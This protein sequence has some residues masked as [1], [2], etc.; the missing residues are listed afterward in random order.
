MDEKSAGEDVGSVQNLYDAFV[1]IAEQYDD[2]AAIVYKAKR[3]TYGQLLTY[4]RQIT[5][6]LLKQSDQG[7]VAIHCE[8]NEYLVA[9]ILGV[10][11]SGRSYLYLDKRDSFAY[12]CSI[13]AAVKCKI[14]LIDN[15]LIEGLPSDIKVFEVQA[16][17]EASEENEAMVASCPYNEIGAVVQSS[18]T[19]GTP[20]LIPVRQSA[21]L[22][23]GQQF[24]QTLDITSN[25]HVAW[26]AS[27]KVAAAHSTFWGSL[28]KGACLY[29]I[30]IHE[31]GINGLIGLVQQASITVLHIAPS[32]FRSLVSAAPLQNLKSVRAVKLGGEAISA[33]DIELFRQTFTR[34]ARLFNGLGI[35]EAGGNVCHIELTKWDKGD[36]SLIPVGRVLPDY[37]VAVINDQGEL[38]PTNQTGLITLKSRHMMPGYIEQS[39][40]SALNESLDG[41]T[42]YIT[43]DLGYFDED[44]CLCVCGRAD[45]VIKIRGYRVDLNVIESQIF[46]ISGIRNVFLD[47]DKKMSKV[48]II[49]YIETDLNESQVGEALSNNL[50]AHCMPAER[51][52]IQDFPKTAGAKIDSA[53]LAQIRLVRRAKY[54][55]DPRDELERLL[56]NIWCK[57]LEIEVVGV[58]D[59]FFQMGGDSLASLELCAQIESTFCIRYRVS[60]LLGHST[61]AR[62]ADIIRRS[63]SKPKG[64]LKFLKTQKTMGVS[65]VQLIK[66]ATRT[67]VVV[68]P[69]GYM[70]ENELLIFVR[71]F[72]EVHL[73]QPI[74]GVKFDTSRRSDYDTVSF[75]NLRKLV[76]SEIAERFAS[77]RIHIIG[78]CVSSSLAIALANDIGQSRVASLTLLDPCR[79]AVR[80]GPNGGE[81]SRLSKYYAMLR[82]ADPGQ[83]HGLINLVNSGNLSAMSEVKNWW[84][85]SLSAAQLR[86]VESGGD[87]ETYL[88]EPSAALLAWVEE[89][90]GSMP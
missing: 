68:L 11:G 52:L 39:G 14:L 80:V 22:S 49:A 26:I 38:L 72:S 6:R 5:H 83:W 13:L 30:N 75:K 9:L 41:S 74:F 8:K 2:H 45:R 29:P 70:S 1:R 88:R 42:A 89:Y 87:H 54:L 82:E 18:G 33:R 86:S 73:E 77:E 20:K 56:A 32:L 40:A 17:L 44:A 59:D 90:F 34:A 81:E 62:M 25:D 61:L 12:Q 55:T 69:G 37:D 31:V 27:P 71:L 58:Y 36:E 19:T 43:G 23:N 67:P 66:R 3:L 51:I 4:S 64:I 79:G 15:A 24:A 60:A 76:Y 50:P 65:I 46:K 35:S 16:W 57:I 78:E 21:L 10:I 53:A 85:G 28:L 63:Q 48:V 84:S 7:P 47:T